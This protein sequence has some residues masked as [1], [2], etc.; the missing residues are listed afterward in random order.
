VEKAAF[1]KDY[2]YETRKDFAG[3]LKRMDRDIYEKLKY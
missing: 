2:V 3:D 1:F